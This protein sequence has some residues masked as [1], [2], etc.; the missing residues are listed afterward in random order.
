MRK[1]GRQIGLILGI[2]I[3]FTIYSLPIEGLNENGKICLAL[4]LMTITFWAFQIT[5]TGY[6]SG[7]YLVLLIILKVAEPEAVFSP[8]MGSTMYLVIGAYLIAAAVKSSG[9]GERISYRFIIK[10]VSSYKSIIVSIFVLTLILSLLI[11]HPWPRAF[12]IMSVMAVVIQSA[13]LPKEDAAK[14]GFA[15]FA[16]EVPVSTIFLTGDS[17]LNPM[18]VQFSGAQI[19][20]FKW[21][22]YMGV[23]GIASSILTFI[24]IMLLF[25]PS[26][27]IKINKADI[28]S[29]L[30]ALGTL[31]K[32]EKRT[33]VWLFIAIVLWLTDSI[34]GINIGWITIL[35][36][37]LMSFPVIGGVLEPKNW[38]DVPVQ[39]LFFVTASISIGKVGAVTGMNSW[40]AQTILPLS[41]SSNPFV[42]ALLITV[43]SIAMHMLFGS[44]LAVMGIAIPALL[45]FSQANSIN[46]VVTALLV[47]L[48]IS[49]HF[50]LPFQ[51]LNILVGLGEENGM[52]TQKEAI[53]LGLPLTVAV[54]VINILVAVPWWKIIGLL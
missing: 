19:G 34:H 42:F 13:E 6:V 49:P 37:M 45:V 33:I 20:W 1:Y 26:V 3:A 15:V 17:L 8:W 11:P 4:T 16:A 31:S 9:L 12:L 40:I 50:I 47:F 18:A 24:L 10:Y 36:A 38:A 27:N 14:I 25:K 2:L 51:H 29:K 48:S 23:P 53:R 44:V 54:F 52:Y 30:N 22:V 5:Q 21:L 35:I 32:I 39:V 46:P 41:V 43:I 7:V 28:Q